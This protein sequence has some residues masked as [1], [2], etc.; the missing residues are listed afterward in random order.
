MGKLTIRQRHVVLKIMTEFF[1]R[2]NNNPLKERVNVILPNKGFKLNT[3]KLIM[4]DF[5]NTIDN[6]LIHSHGNFI[7]SYHCIQL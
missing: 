6:L 4:D 5:Y 1:C 3:I 7:E 2:L